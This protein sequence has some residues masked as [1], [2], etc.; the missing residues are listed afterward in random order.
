M[1]SKVQVQK[2]EKGDFGRVWSHTECSAEQ[3]DGNKRKKIVT[4]SFRAHVEIW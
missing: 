3:L 1:Y 2:N 4:C